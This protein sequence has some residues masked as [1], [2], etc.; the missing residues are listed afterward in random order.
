MKDV[1]WRDWIL[2]GVALVLLFVGFGLLR[3]AEFGPPQGWTG[4]QGPL[5]FKRME[6]QLREQREPSPRPEVQLPAPG[7]G[8]QS[9]VDDPGDQRLSETVDTGLQEVRP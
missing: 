8:S 1:D 3:V 4:E 5:P 6:R 7:R 9:A 2:P